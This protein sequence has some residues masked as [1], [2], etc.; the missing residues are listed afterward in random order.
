MSIK[1]IQERLL[2]YQ[3]RSEKEEKQALREITQEVILAALGRGDFFNY[4]IFQ[5]G[6]CLR[7]FYGLNRFSEDLDFILINPD[8]KFDINP[9]LQKVADECR[10]FGYRIE[11][12]DRSR[13]GAAIKPAFLKEDSLGRVLQLNYVGR[14]GRMG[15]IRIKFEVDTNPPAGFGREMKYLDFPFVSMVVLQDKSGLFAGKIHALLCREYIKGRDWYDFIWYTGQKISI[16]FKFLSAAMDQQGPWQ[17]KGINIDLKWC[18]REL[19][20]KIKS[21]D[22]PMVANDVRRFVR[23]SEY[24]SLDLWSKDLLL[25]QLSK[26]GR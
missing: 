8:W 20:R 12:Q 18:I 9:H 21:L 11:I 16:D 1:L 23:D 26:I 14:T 25:H 4:A 13:E 15:N 6:T 5:G 10:A 19:T 17:G 22:W 24:S 7:I 2:S 3:C